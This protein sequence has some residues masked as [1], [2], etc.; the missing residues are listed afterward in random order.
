MLNGLLAL[1]KTLRCTEIP[2]IFNNT[3]LEDIA[4]AIYEYNE[5]EIVWPTQTFED[6]SHEYLAR[7]KIIHH[8]KIHHD[9]QRYFT[10]YI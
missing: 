7:R 1:I 8:D 9:L 3:I 6:G 10:E 5:N 2:H 4:N